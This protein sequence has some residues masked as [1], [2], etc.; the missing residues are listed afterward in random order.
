MSVEDKRKFL[1]ESTYLSSSQ[2]GSLVE[3]KKLAVSRHLLRNF[4]ENEKGS[5]FEAFVK[6]F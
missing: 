3:M 4:S 6:K 5:G 2:G 1:R